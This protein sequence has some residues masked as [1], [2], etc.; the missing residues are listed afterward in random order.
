MQLQNR[1]KSSKLQNTIDFFSHLTLL[2][3]LFCFW[4]IKSMKQNMVSPELFTYSKTSLISMKLLFWN[5]NLIIL[6]LLL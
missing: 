4:L 3:L 1:I 2:S 5:T 6:K